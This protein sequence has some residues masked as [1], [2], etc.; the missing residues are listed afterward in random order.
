MSPPH[1]RPKA[2]EPPLGGDARSAR[3]AHT[4]CTA[5][6]QIDGLY[7]GYGLAQV[8]RGIDLTLQAGEIVAVLGRNGS[9]RSTLL[10][11]VMGLLPAQG[12]LLFRGQEVQALPTHRRALLGL[13]YVS[14][15]RDV[16]PR[17]SVRQNLLLGSKPPAFADA[18]AGWS[19][20]RVL[21]LFPPLQH[22][23]LAP[24]SA[25]SGGEQQ[26][27]AIARALMGNPR[28][29]LLDEPTEGLAPQ[30]VQATAVLLRQLR[31]AG[32]GVLL[33]EQRLQLALDVADRV[34]VLGDGQVQFTG[35]GA[36]LQD[37][38]EVSAAWL[39]F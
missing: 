23:L 22:R 15:H 28:V 32:L 16:F 5:L 14:E 10:K 38:P 3:G 20:H 12:R 29:L 39:G 8:L 11:A 13:G 31:A 4:T 34:A 7:A 24:A 37:H 17:M 19:E 33:V 18:A 6:L 2:G 35:S 36:E 21:D 25:L 27:L 30:R 26:M 9:G 1:G